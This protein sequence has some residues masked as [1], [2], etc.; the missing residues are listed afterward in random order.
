MKNHYKVML[1]VVML[2]GAHCSQAAQA[3]KSP[4]KSDFKKEF[5]Q[6]RH[7]ISRLKKELSEAQKTCAAIRAEMGP[8]EA[9]FELM[10]H[11]EKNIQCPNVPRYNK[12]QEDF[13]RENARVQKT[14]QELA[15]FFEKKE[16]MVGLAL[17][18]ANEK[19]KG[20]LTRSKS[21]EKK[22]KALSLPCTLKRQGAKIFSA[23]ASLKFKKPRSVEK[24]AE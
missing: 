9:I 22:K 5:L 20:A 1:C 15:V 7:T 12:L 4:L 21:P 2:S 23:T 17:A 10:K 18:A 3:K 13:K 19:S 16:D 6:V 24:S 14:S 11:G 8:M